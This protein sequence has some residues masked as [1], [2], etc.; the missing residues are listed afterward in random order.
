MIKTSIILILKWEGEQVVKEEFPDAIIFR[1]SD[2]WGTHD[3]FLNYYMSFSKYMYFLFHTFLLLTNC[4]TNIDKNAGFDNKNAGFD[5]RF[6]KYTL[7][8]CK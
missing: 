6:L 7:H 5:F 1:P 2:I 4:I 3:H 8:T